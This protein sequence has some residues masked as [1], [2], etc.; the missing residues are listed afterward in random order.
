MSVFSPGPAK[1]PRQKS[2]FYLVCDISKL[3]QI[4]PKKRFQEVQESYERT[5][6]WTDQQTLLWRNGTHLKKEFPAPNRVL[7]RSLIKEKLNEKK[8]VSDIFFFR[9]WNKPTSPPAVGV[10]ATP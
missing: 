8:I 7:P 4:V 5:D 6:R 3:C 10:Q 1:R 2:A 9:E